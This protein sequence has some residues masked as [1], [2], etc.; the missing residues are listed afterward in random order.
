MEKKI[1]K[2]ITEIIK[3]NEQVISIALKQRAKFE[4]WLKYMLVQCA[5]ENNLEEI[6]VE[7]K[8]GR[9]KRADIYFQSENIKYYVELKT[10]NTNW[11][12]DGIEKRTRPITK[13]I[14]G[15]IKDAKKLKN[16]RVNGIVAFV[17]FPI[18]KDD[19]RWKDHVSRIEKKVN[20]DISSD[21]HYSKILINNC[22]ILIF[23][24]KV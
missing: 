24:F 20:V 21:G 22:E 17:L 10:A 23:S 2:W 1:L 6:R 5:I 8:Y 4:G 18:P 3:S 15:I 16:E 19:T 9:N 7:A 12:I 13:N 14:T 11:K